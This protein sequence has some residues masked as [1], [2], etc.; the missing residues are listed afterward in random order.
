MAS[1]LF[2]LQRNALDFPGWSISWIIAEIR[3]ITSSSGSKMAFNRGF[4]R[5]YDVACITSAAWVELWY[6]LSRY[7]D[8]TTTSQLRKVDSSQFKF[9]QTLNED[10]IDSPRKNN[11]LRKVNQTEKHQKTKKKTKFINANLK[12]IYLF[13]FLLCFLDI[14]LGIYI[15]QVWKRFFLQQNANTVIIIAIKMTDMMNEGQKSMH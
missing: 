6:G 14:F 2:E 12:V 9:E 1:S 8:S 13:I 7:C 11:G 4:L 10:N 3:L 15:L 5:K